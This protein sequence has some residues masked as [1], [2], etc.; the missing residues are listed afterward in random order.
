MKAGWISSIAF[1]VFILPYAMAAQQTTD[2]NSPVELQDYLRYAALHNVS[3]KASF[4]RWRAAVENVPQAKVLPDPRFTYGYFIEEVET[5]VG[6]Q[7]HRFELMQTFPWFGT[8]EA[9]TDKA[10]AMAKA[11]YKQYEMNK[12]RLFEQVKYSFYEY[13][14]LAKS[15]GITRENLELVKNFEEV[16]RTRYATSASTHPDIIRAQIELAILEDRLRSLEELRP[17]VTTRLNSVLN[18]PAASGLPW[19]KMHE[20]QE[21]SIEFPELYEIIVR[22]NPG[23][24]AADFEIEAARSGERL[25]KK[26]SYPSIGLGVSYIETAHA[27]ASGVRD[28]GKDPVMAMISLNLPVWTDSYKAA[29]NQAHAQIMEKTFEKAQM[30]NNLG[31]QGQQLLYELK[32]SDRKIRLY[33][34]V[35]IPKAR[36]MLLASETAYRAANVDFLSLIDAERTLL[37]YQL[38]LERL[39]AENSQKL[40]QLETLAGKQLP[41][42]QAQRGGE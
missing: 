42:K 30:E 5:R 32:D 3:L 19:P 18:R 22:N 9:R 20:H 37:Q 40:A 26:Q 35:I 4:E 12:L 29:R 25:A 23:L 17:A 21:T 10:S 38:Y 33:S 13:C 28:S 39:I 8:I 15:I 6:P 7:R 14:Y 34:E 41:V 24:Q 31:A 2:A 1:I 16:A 11:A 36:E 27:M